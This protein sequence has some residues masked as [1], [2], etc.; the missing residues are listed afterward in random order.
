MRFSTI[1]VAGFAAYSQAERV[2]DERSLRDLLGDW[3][4]PNGIDA[5]TDVSPTAAP[6]AGDLHVFHPPHHDVVIDDCDNQEADD[7]HWV[8]PGTE[9]HAEDHQWTTSTITETATETVVDCDPE[10]PCHGGGKTHYTTVTI[11]ETVTICPVPITPEPQ[12]EPEP[13]GEPEPEPEPTGEPEPEPEPPV[14]PSEV[15]VYPSE[16]PEPAPEPTYEPEPEPPVSEVPPPPEETEPV[17]PPPEEP[18][19]EPP[20][21]EA[22]PPPEE[23]EPVQPPPEE[24]E[25]EPPV[26]SE[27][28][29]EPTEAP[30]PVPPPVPTSIGTVTI[31]APPSEETTS[32]IPVPTAGAGQ[33]A[34][35]AG[36]AVVAAAVAAMLI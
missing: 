25:P 11:P 23:T 4:Y 7:W 14:Y 12:P 34:Q 32:F 3:E 30:L 13:T 21:S 26:E 17:H 19:P 8:H 15:P 22:P 33:N 20:V 27:P 6:E 5:L 28:V 16:E 35:R 18:E 24:P 1:A 29:Y 36:G 2:N 9:H 31:P 10:E